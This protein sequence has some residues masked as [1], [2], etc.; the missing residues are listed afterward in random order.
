MKKLII[1]DYYWYTGAFNVCGID[2]MKI[3]V[4]P[5]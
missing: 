3:P 1:T 2:W 4:Q 5:D